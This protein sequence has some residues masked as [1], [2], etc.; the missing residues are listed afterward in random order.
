MKI[1]VNL[2]EGHSDTMCQE[3]LK[4]VLLLSQQF[5]SWD[6]PEAFRKEILGKVY[7]VISNSKRLKVD[8]MKLH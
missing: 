6:F 7:N 5:H 3:S 2:L 4:I 8:E 1:S